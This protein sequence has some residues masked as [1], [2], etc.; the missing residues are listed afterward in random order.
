MNLWVMLDNY[1][2]VGK[3]ISRNCVLKYIVNLNSYQVNNFC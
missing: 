2:V 3:R 1:Q